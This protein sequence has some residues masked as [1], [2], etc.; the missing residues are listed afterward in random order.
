MKTFHASVIFAG[1]LTSTG[2]SFASCADQAKGDYPA[3]T[4]ALIQSYAKAN[5]FSGT[6][7]IAC[8]GK[9]I[10][11]RGFGMAN[12]EWNIPNALDTKFRLGS[13]TKIFTATAILQLAEQGKLS[14][15]DPVSKYYTASPASWRRITIKHLLTHQSGIPDYADPL[16]LS[17]TTARTEARIDRA[18]EALIELFRD[19]PLQFEPGS[20]VS[21][22]NSGY[23]VLGVII[24]NLSG[25]AYAHY[26]RKHILEPL[27]MHDSGYDLN[28]KIIPRRAAGYVRTTDDWQNAPFLA[29]SIPYSAG[30]LYSTVSDLLRLDHAFYALKPL[31][32]ASQKLMFTN[33]GD[34]WGMGWNIFQQSGHDQFANEGEVNGFHTGIARYPDDK[35]K[36]IVLSNFEGA[37]IEDI[38]DDL[39]L[40]YLGIPK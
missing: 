37:P 40:L 15:D 33:Y 34:H 6:V 3:K 38:F 14:I 5:E 36:I 18:P 13:L 11:Q 9:P 24:E 1:L 25:E 12:W 4:T 31:S 27:G 16:V 32:A 19:K 35:L 28:E 2:S 10:F 20:Q 26:I 22:S 8:A 30:S 17:P 21:Y 23:V 29:M 39:K 7:L